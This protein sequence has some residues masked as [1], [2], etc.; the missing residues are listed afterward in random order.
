MLDSYKKTYEECADNLIKEDWRKMN[1]NALANKYVEVMDNEPLANAYIS[2]I[3]CRY[4]SN[5]YK[6]Y[7]KSHNVVDNFTLHSWLVG[8]ITRALKNHKWLDPSSSVYG[9]PNGPDKVINRCIMSER[10]GFFQN[11]N[12]YKRKCN[13]GLYSL[14]KIS[15]DNPESTDIPVYEDSDLD[16]G[17]ISINQFI[18]NCFDN[19]NYMLAFIVD[20]IV[21]YDV[22]KSTTDEN[23]NSYMVF[24]EKK[25]IHHLHC[26]DQDYC[27]LFAA[28]FKK[29]KK[30]VEESVDKCISLSRN[31]LKVMVERGL[32]NLRRIYTKV[33]EEY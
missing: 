30:E 22:F 13:F 33:L 21:N 29:D 6:Y 2:A 25:L 14:D 23:N 9:D 8:A 11:S 10:L 4:W 7:Y 12:T 18:S 19:H 15:E 32:R 3:I 27:D 17:T 26:L 24:N 1:K 5:L 20:G 28:R 16:D 31:T